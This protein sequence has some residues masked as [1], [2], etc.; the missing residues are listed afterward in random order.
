MADQNEELQK[1]L[2]RLGVVR[3]AGQLKPPRKLKP[4]PPV[5]GNCYGRSP[6][7]HPPTF[8]KTTTSNL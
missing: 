4:A 7:Q 2:R 3:G 6:P 5:D 8:L 1:K